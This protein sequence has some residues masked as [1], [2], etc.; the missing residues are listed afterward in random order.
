MLNKYGQTPLDIAIQESVSAPGVVGKVN[1]L[2]PEKRRRHDVEQ[3]ASYR[4]ENANEKTRFLI[5]HMQKFS[6]ECSLKFIK[7][8]QRLDLKFE[9]S[10]AL[11]VKQKKTDLLELF[12]P[13]S[14]KNVYCSMHQLKDYRQYK[15]DKSCLQ[16]QLTTPLHLAC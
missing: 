14:V 1:G 13:Y 11:C 15:F 16:E 7:K 6:S 9:K 2:L 5:N 8:P 10:F 4:I 12:P 3:G